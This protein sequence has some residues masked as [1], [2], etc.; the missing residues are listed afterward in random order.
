MTLYIIV[1]SYYITKCYYS[2]YEVLTLSGKIITEADK[3]DE[4]FIN[5]YQN[6]EKTSM[7]LELISDSYYIAYEVLT[8][9]TKKAVGSYT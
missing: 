5:R 6:A 9:S 8:F 7:M 3:L 2:A 4:E 1:S